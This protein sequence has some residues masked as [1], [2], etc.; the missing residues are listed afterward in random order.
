MRVVASFRRSGAGSEPSSAWPERSARLYE[1][2]RRPA[3]AMVRRAF[4]RAF[5][6]HEVEDIYSN[7]WLGTLRALAQPPREAERRGDPQVR[8]RLPSRT[9]RARSF[10]AAGGGRP[11]RSTLSTRSRTTGCPRMN[12]R[13]SSSTGGLTR[14][15]LSTLPPRRRAVMLLRYG[16]GL[17]PSSGLRLVKGLSPRAYRK[18]ITRGV[19]ELT[20][21]LRLVER[22]EWC[23]DREPV[24]KAYAAGLADPDRSARR[25]S[26]CPIAAIARISSARL[27]GHL[28]DVG[29]SVAVP[30]AAEAMRDGR[31]LARGPHR[32]RRTPGA[33]PG[34]RRFRRTGD[35]R[36]VR[37]CRAGGER[38]RLRSRRRCGG[39]RSSRQ[40]RGNR[41]GGQAGDGLPGRGRGCDRLFGGRSPADGPARP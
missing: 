19:D 11:P 20:E 16:W 10:V 38:A 15:L 6:D 1:E 17:E 4:R 7:A 13:R 33:G 14:D 9:T 25:S 29:A 5:D 30:T 23:A 35:G 3:R 18:E 39:H 12:A 40:A 41:D 32:R 36:R 22:G 8:A 21:K 28:H 34:G 26:T 24:L 2:L 37:R 27:S 31:L